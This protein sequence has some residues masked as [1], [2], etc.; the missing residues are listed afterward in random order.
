MSCNIANNGRTNINYENV[1]PYGNSSGSFASLETAFSPSAPMNDFQNKM[2]NKNPLFIQNMDSDNANINNNIQ[3]MLKSCHSDEF[4]ISPQSEEKIDNNVDQMIGALYNRDLEYNKQNTTS[5]NKQYL[6]PHIPVVQNGVN[7]PLNR[8]QHYSAQQYGTEL[9]ENFDL[10]RDA[11][12][13]WDNT[14]NTSY[15]LTGMSFFKF[16]LLLILIAVLVYGIYW[17]Y[18]NNTETK[19][20]TSGDTVNVITPSTTTTSASATKAFERLIRRW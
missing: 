12:N 20:I 2:T 15:S 4:K 6:Y 14:N 11:Q 5:V 1:G 18:T 16:L 13:I 3:T 10:Q 19:V 17:L 9:L 7:F 8:Q